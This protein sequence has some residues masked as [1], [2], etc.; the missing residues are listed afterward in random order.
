MDKFRKELY[1]AVMEYTFTDEEG[2][3]GTRNPQKGYGHDSSSME[4][5]LD[6]GDMAKVNQTNSTYR[7]AI[8]IF[9]KVVGNRFVNKGELR[10]LINE[11]VQSLDFLN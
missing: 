1:D 7:K 3:K 5:N 2:R 4:F 9:R 10:N 6:F 8:Q 11:K